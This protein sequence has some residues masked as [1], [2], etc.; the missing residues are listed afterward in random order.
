MD[1]DRH[2]PNPARNPARNQPH[3]MSPDPQPRPALPTASPYLQPS[4][5]S[6]RQLH[7]YLPPSGM[8]QPH[9][10]AQATSAYPYPPPVPYAGPSSA[11]PRLSPPASS[12]TATHPRSELLES[13]AEGDAEPQGPAKKKRR[14]QALSC[15]EHNHAD[16][17]LD[18][19]NSR[20]VSGAPWSPDKYVT[21][22]EYEAL[23]DQS[24][25]EYDQ[26]KRRLDQL[27]SMVSRFFS[28]PPGGTVGMPLYPTPQDISGSSSD[29]LASYHSGSSSQ[30]VYTPSLPP[31]ASYHAETTP[32]HHY[33]P[34]AIPESTP[35]ASA[36]ATQAPPGSGGFGHIRRPSDGKSPTQP[37]QSPLSLASITSPYNPDSQSKNWA[38]QMLKLLGE[39]LRLAQEGW[40]GPALLC[41]I[42]QQWNNPRQHR[43]CRML[44][45]EDRRHLPRGI[46]FPVL[47]LKGDWRILLVRT[48]V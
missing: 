25:T 33:Y 31:P 40:K 4:L 39:C 11:D 9:L 10:P 45:W 41:G 28:A 1:P 16:L 6:I 22:Q 17:A 23:R 32:K 21:R 47:R 7:P 44:P 46:T 29:N 37:R 2:L 5:P 30:A 42:R 13:E 43:V 36:S 18:V 15:N 8:P 19:A 38:A 27:E 35:Q 3:L 20:S 34:T 14:R 12:H 48:R 24:R 26:L